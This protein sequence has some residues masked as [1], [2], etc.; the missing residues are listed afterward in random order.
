MAIMSQDSHRA[1]AMISE[2]F[3]S[4]VSVL[5]NAGIT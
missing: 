5:L 2:H 3:D 1:D 4:A